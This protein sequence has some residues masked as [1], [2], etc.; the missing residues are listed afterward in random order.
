MSFSAADSKYARVVVDVPTQALDRAFD[1]IVPPFLRD[2]VTIGSY[3]VVPLGSRKVGGYVIELGNAPAIAEPTKL[4]EIISV[5]G[6]SPLLTPDMID[7]A[8]WVK[9]RYACRAVDVL[10]AMLPPSTR[11]LKISQ[12]PA[13]RRV[14]PAAQASD[15]KA[16]GE[17]GMKSPFALTPAQEKALSFI[18]EAL[19]RKDPKPILLHGV[20]ASGKTEVYLRAIQTC[21]AR[22]NSAIVLVPEI[23]IT[24][25]MVDRFRERFGDLVAVLHSRLSGGERAK[26]WERL[27]RGEAMVAIGARSCVFAP[28]RKLGLIVVDEEHEGSYKQEEAPRYHAREVAIKRASIQGAVVL[29]GSATPSIETSYHTISGD[30]R[31]VSLPD[32][33]DSR[34]LPHVEIV[35]MKEEHASGNRGVFSRRLSAAIREHLERGESIM[36]FLNRRGYSTFVLCRECGHALRCPDCDVSLTM[37]S[38]EGVMRCHWCGHE[39][40]IPNICPNCKG[41]RIGQYGIGTERVEKEVLRAFPGAKVLRMDL[42]TTRR[43]GSHEAILS[44]FSR[45]EYNVLVGTQMI[46][47]GLDF[48]SV[49]L[50][51]VI[52]ADISLN[53]PDFRSSERT[54]QLLVQVAGRSG[55]GN[56]PGKVVIQTYCPSHYAVLYAG[57]YD[58]EGFYA[59]ELALR[60]ELGSPPFSHLISV[61]TTSEDEGKVVQ[62]VGQLSSRFRQIASQQGNPFLQ[63]L[64][65]SPL[66]VK[67]VKRVYRWHIILKVSNVI[68]G[69]EI[70]YRI[71]SE[72]AK[73]YARQGVKVAIDV[74]PQSMI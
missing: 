16:F 70:A 11:A 55:R 18:E 45:G 12:R 46:A 69:S 27:A 59:K 21:I 33:I 10:R 15:S 17:A 47:K 8:L 51:G 29:L 28:C 2:D 1:Y 74:D 48:P 44:A 32:R 6:S 58:Y 72:T 5:S 52:S 56:T 38:D 34:P 66:P 39:E 3:V 67:R 73:A 54:F 14:P 4:K 64:G 40:A 22:G 68:K 63:V 49:T 26:E 60:Q 71:A 13:K 42:D 20:T 50:V 23:S 57:R 36:L 30:Y 37:H 24:P 43:K 25:Q 9:D 65:P 7:L 31:L 53:L 41:H 35:D 61:M 62:A 19:L